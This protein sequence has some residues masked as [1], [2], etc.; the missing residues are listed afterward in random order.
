MLKIMNEISVIAAYDVESFEEEKS[1][2]LLSKGWNGW[3]FDIDFLA[4]EYFKDLNNKGFPI[5]LDTNRALYTWHLFI[6]GKFFTIFDAFGMVM[7][8]LEK[9]GWLGD[10][11]IRGF[12]NAV[13]DVLPYQELWNKENFKKEYTEKAIKCYIKEKF[14]EEISKA[15]PYNG[16]T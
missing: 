15:K 4:F 3:V 12:I 2:C 14:A 13:N 9:R 8:I 5:T 16:G 7:H 10:K 6:E 1:L 11:A